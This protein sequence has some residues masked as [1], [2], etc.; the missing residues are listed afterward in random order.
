MDQDTQLKE[1]LRQVRRLEIRTERVVDSLAAGAYRSRFKGQGMEFEEVR[2]YA[3]GDDVRH[4]DWNVTARAGGR[5]YVKTF[6]EER[7]LT[8]MVLVDLSGSMRYGAIPGVSQ[9]SK[10]HAA[11][12]A[13]A[14]L[15]I[16][17]MRN[18][19]FI[20][21][22]GFTD[23]TEIHLP[24]RKGRG[25]AMRVIRE[26]LAPRPSSQPTDTCHALRELI[27][28]STKR[29]VCFVISDFLEPEPELGAVLAQVGRRHDL[30]GLRVADPAEANI[31][32]GA[33][34]V[35]TDPEGRGEQVL[36]AS[37]KAA[38]RY[39]AAYAANRDA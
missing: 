18:N 1:L 4:I 16:T 21:L 15:G 37:K 32:A 20:G 33:P 23:K 7:D 11:A 36:R 28:V 29:S 8:V 27:R 5:A 9:R 35:I 39:A 38:A 2:E 13:A 30:I 12:E 6:R 22:L 34:L 10:L 31:P 26:C 17:A 24:P 14:V 19:D 3:A 25:H